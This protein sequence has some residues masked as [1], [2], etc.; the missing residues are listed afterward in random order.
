MLKESSP[1]AGTSSGQIIP[2]EMDRKG[3]ELSNKTG[4]D[5]AGSKESVSE[6]VSSQTNLAEYR[7]SGTSAGS[8]LGKPTL[9]ETALKE[10]ESDTAARLPK[11]A[12]ETPVKVKA[13]AEAYERKALASSSKN[14]STLG[15]YVTQEIGGGRKSGA[16]DVDLHH[17]VATL[18]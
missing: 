1:S 8:L 16:G 5:S 14:R 11:F 17:W 15:E 9:R 4:R 10:N 12:V 6:M 18:V 13:M 2:R 7:E 3:K